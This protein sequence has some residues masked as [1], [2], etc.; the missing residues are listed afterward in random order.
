MV[1]FGTLHHMSIPITLGYFSNSYYTIDFGHQ[2][3]DEQA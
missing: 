3:R 2:T 1:Q